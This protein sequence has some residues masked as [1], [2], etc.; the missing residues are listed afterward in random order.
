MLARQN[1]LRQICRVNAVRY[2]HTGRMRPAGAPSHTPER[3]TAATDTR[4]TVGTATVINVGDVPTVLP[5]KGKAE[6]MTREQVKNLTKEY[7]EYLQ[8]PWKLSK[9]IERRLEKDRYEEALALVRMASS[10]GQVVVSWN[11]LI[12]Y[13][14]RKQ[15][16][17]GGMKLFNEVFPL[18]LSPSHTKNLTPFF[19]NR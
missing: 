6:G 8:N 15:R 13:F 18:R 12:D 3:R 5:S 7:K 10:D 17:H 14:F 9:A 19:L 16:L 1:C 4:T 11:I 2:A